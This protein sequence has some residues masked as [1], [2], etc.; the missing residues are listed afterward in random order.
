MAHILHSRRSA[1]LLS[2]VFV[3]LVAGG[4]YFFHEFGLAL[5]ML[6]ALAVVMAFTAST[7]RAFCSAVCPRGRALGFA[8]APVALRRSLPHL[9]SS[10]A[11]RRFFCGTTMF[12]VFM[13][14]FQVKSGV[15]VPA[16]T[17]FVFWILCLASLSTGLVLGFVFR[18]R[19]WCALCPLGTLQDTIR[20]ARAGRA[21]GVRP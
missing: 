1:D 5:A 15:S 2:V 12:L 14:L 19:T 18:P 9:L 4:G 17:G 20:E 11:F 10:R 16:W 7:P 13:S 21:S 3:A 8:L 6:M